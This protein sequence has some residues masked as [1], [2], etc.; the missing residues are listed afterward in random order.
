V[1]LP[2]ALDGPAFLVVVL[3]VVGGASQA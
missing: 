2:Q 3:L 1:V